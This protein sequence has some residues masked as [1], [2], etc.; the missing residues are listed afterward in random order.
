MIGHPLIYHKEMHTTYTS[1]L[2]FHFV[3]HSN[4]DDHSANYDVLLKV[5]HD[6]CISHSPHENNWGKVSYTINWERSLLDEDE[7][8]IVPT[9]TCFTD[10][11]FESLG[12]HVKKYGKFGLSFQRELLMKYGARPVMYV[13]LHKEDWGSING[14][15]MLKDIE[16]I[17][18][19]FHGIVVSKNPFFGEMSVRHLGTMPQN[20]A[21][22]VM[23]INNV[24]AKDFL[25]FIK[26]FNTHLEE[27]HPDNFY[28]EREWRKHGNL[29]FTTRDVENII[30][31]KGYSSRLEMAF[32]QYKG[33][34]VEI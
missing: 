12:I 6:E 27:N 28:M 25:A 31:A 13:P 24:F 10:I 17:Y 16:A 20:E 21:E 23:G 1:N 9:V 34:V 26:P 19:S 4:P 18:K 33:K 7:K 2:L 14:E 11:P 3:G 15:T 8:L 5:L 29:K 22:A 32:P 30:V